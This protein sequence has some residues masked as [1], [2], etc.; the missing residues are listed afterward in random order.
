MV[1]PFKA[2]CLRLGRQLGGPV[3]PASARASG[4]GRCSQK[5]PLLLLLLLLLLHRQQQQ[6]QLQ[7]S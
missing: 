3:S 2:L 4:T 7:Q 6:Q 1:S 5:T